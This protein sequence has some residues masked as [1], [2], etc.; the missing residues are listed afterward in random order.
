[1][2]A[3]GVGT[4]EAARHPHELGTEGVRRGAPI[5]H[6]VAALAALDLHKQRVVGRQ[7]QGALEVQAVLGVGLQQI[8]L[9]QFEFWWKNFLENSSRYYIKN[10]M[11]NP[12]EKNL[13]TRSST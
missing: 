1:M 10:I 9:Q 4:A 12:V 2:P 11:R 5:A 6:A 13:E 8:P 3:S 7:Q